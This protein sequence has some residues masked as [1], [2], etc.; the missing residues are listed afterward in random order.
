M[1]EAL[2]GMTNMPAL[3]LKSAWKNGVAYIENVHG[4]AAIIMALM[5]PVIIGGLAFGAEVGGWELTKRKIQNAADIAAFAAGTQIRSG[6]SGSDLD[7]AALEV[8]EESG[9]KS[10]SSGLEV[11]Y[12]PTSAPL[13]NDSLNPGTTV[14]PNGD[15]EY[16]YV[17]L[18]ETVQ[19]NFTRYFSGASTS[20]NIVSEAV[21]RIQNGRP[22]CVLSLAPNSSDAINVAGNTDVTLTGCDLAANS[23]ASDAV[24]QD[25]N[26]EL[27]T[28]CISTVGGTDFQNDS[29][30]T[31]NDC[32]TPIENAPYTPDPYRNV[33]QPNTSLPCASTTGGPNSE[34]NQ[35]ATGNNKTGNPTPSIDS[36]GTVTF[37]KYCGG[38]TEQIQGV[39]N[40]SPGVYILDGGNW[41]VSGAL[42]GDGVTLFLTNG[43]TL[44]I[45]A[46]ATID[47]S[48]PTTG[49][50]SGLVIFFDRSNTGDSV[51]NGGANFSLVGAV[52][53]VKQD[54]TFTGNTTGSGPGECT[55]II[56][57][58]VHF[59]GN[60]DFDTDCSASGTTAILA[61][62][63]IKVVG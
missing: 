14:D 61:G 16:V 39:T 46:G 22:A 9:Y 49:T 53:G 25:G 34:F 15:S 5:T 36:T 11:Q 42:Q 32:G 1:R 7:I 2:T 51:I 21:A 62:Q 55:Q 47:L 18:T 3:N 17:V 28:D 56:G 48:A 44:D 33:A 20:V 58:T 4:G 50:Y 26:A 30:V 57:Y 35:F 27:E 10:G 60:S 37:K 63:S 6:K 40:L 12:P 59:T 54:I 38:T 52:Y 41:H 8:A 13:V 43:A 31:L 23:L 19:R 24:T 29:N 45:N